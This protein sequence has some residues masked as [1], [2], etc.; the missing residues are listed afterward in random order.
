MNKWI[1]VG[2]GLLATCLLLGSCGE[3]EPYSGT[4]IEELATAFDKCLEYK[5]RIDNNYQYLCGDYVDKCKSL[6]GFTALNPAKCIK[7]VMCTTTGNSF[8]CAGFGAANSSPGQLFY[9]ACKSS[10]C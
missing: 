1:M 3:S 2:G 4:E 8:V 6:I 5:N 7:N 10:G 9:E